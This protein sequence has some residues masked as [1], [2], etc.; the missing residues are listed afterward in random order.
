MPP[1]AV[2]HIIVVMLENRSYDNMLGWLY[3]AGNA[4]PYNSAP[5]GQSDLN[6]LTGMESNPAP[7]GESIGVSNASTTSTPIHDPGEDFRDMAQQIFGLDSPAT[8][9]PWVEP[10]PEGMTG[11]VRNYSTQLDFLD[12]AHLPDCITYYTPEQL[13]VT[14]FLANK[15]ALCDQWYASVPCQTYTNRSFSISAGPPVCVK[16]D[17]HPS[18]V[19]YSLVND[20]AY[21][22][23]NPVLGNLERLPSIF[24]ALDQ[25]FPDDEVN[26]KV[27]FHDYSISMQVSPYVFEAAKSSVNKNV[28][29]FD[30]T[31][32]PSGEVPSFFGLF[33]LGAVTT[34]F[35]EDLAA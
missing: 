15:Y 27:Y 29:T 5:P 25:T 8:E 7:D 3:K 19:P 10:P 32:Y 18:R 24:E 33:Q 12:R 35:L 1:S 34:T 31:D 17:L 6:G 4:P 22:E 16:N 9:N 11:F 14:S 13:P 21:V 2:D 20:S 23:A 28:A 30:N 26:W